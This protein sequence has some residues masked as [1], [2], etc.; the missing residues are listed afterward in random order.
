MMDKVKADGK[1]KESDFR[2]TCV[3]IDRGRTASRVNLDRSS[4]AVVGVVRQYILANSGQRNRDRELR[5][6][7]PNMDN[8]N[9]IFFLFLSFPRGKRND[10]PSAQ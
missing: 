3:R 9:P 7:I 5:R 1:E 4:R 8:Q 10:S 6:M 2:A